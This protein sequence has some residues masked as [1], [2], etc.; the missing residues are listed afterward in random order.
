MKKL[1]FALY[2]FT[3]TLFLSA[4]LFAVF[5]KSVREEGVRPG[6]ITS[7]FSYFKVVDSLQILI[8]TQADN[9]GLY[10]TDPSEKGYNE[11][12]FRAPFNYTKQTEDSV[13]KLNK[14]IVWII[15][16][17]FVDGVTSTTDDKTFVELLRA[18]MKDCSIWSF[19]AGGADP[20][21]YQLTI[22]KYLV[23]QE[24]HPDLIIVAFCGA[25]DAMPFERVP[26]PKVPMYYFTNA[27][28]LSSIPTL[29]DPFDSTKHIALK[30]P[31]EAYQYYLHWLSP[32]NKNT[33]AYKF[34]KHSALI[35]KYYGLY[36]LW[37]SFKTYNNSA[38]TCQASYRHLKYIDAETEQKH[39][40]FKMVYIPD[41][42]N[43]YGSPTDTAFEKKMNYLFK[44]LQP[45]VRFPT[46][47]NAGT[48]YILTGYEASHFNDAGN[49]KFAD[50][51][52]PLIRE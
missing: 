4:I 23:A 6:I 2:I 30:T 28:S 42:K 52:K 3:A 25:N 7:A 34:C 11:Q 9:N 44:D 1:K 22:N 36:L 51:L 10:T 21:N 19:G 31:Y 43:L 32:R 13:K 49:R 45:L 37:N 29:Q 48:H 47:F 15:G 46:G 33:M 27:G 40:P 18:E 50:F 17:S 38:D 35:T 20:L 5:E 24:L 26:E 41:M 14:K 16:D 12:G 39:I 8:K